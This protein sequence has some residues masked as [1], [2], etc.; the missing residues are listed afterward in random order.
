MI[1]ALL[2]AF[3]LLAAAGVP[4]AVG[5]GIAVILTMAFFTPLPTIGAMQR[6]ITGVDSFVLISIP[7]FML[8]G[9]L[10]NVGGITTRLFAFARSLVGPIRGGMAHANVLA[11]MILAGMSGSAVADAGGM[12]VVVIKAM[13]SQ[14]YR[15][16][17]AAAIT[18]AASTI[19]PII[20]PSIPMVI[21]GAMAEVS[22]GKLFLG[23]FVPGVL[24]GLSLMGLIAFWS[25]RERLPADQPYHLREI[26]KAFREAFLS[27]LTPIILIGGILSGIFTPTEA[28]AVAAVYAFVLSFFILRTVKVADIPGII[29]DTFVTTAVVTFI[30]STTSGF[31]YLL[32]I[33]KIGTLLV[34]S[35][36]ALTHNP[37]VV[38][39]IVNVA[40][41]ILG[42]LMEAGVLLIL[43]TP[44]LVP[45]MKSL[46]VDLV[47]FGLIM[48]LNL[49]IGVATPPVGMCLFVV[50]EAN[51]IKL[52]R[53]MREVIP[54][55]VPLILVLFLITYIPGL[56]MW[57]PNWLMAGK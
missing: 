39:L 14:G 33:G 10:M 19:G 8:T 26:W 41:L 35:T 37:Y 49:M 40:L 22:V 23:G 18:V 12:G 17:L 7:F 31:S 48:V 50:S 57:V 32:I 30:I 43:L 42:C 52:E 15:K 51:N 27:L 4:I 46:G 6:M 25:R 44:I 21:Y 5:M 11:N 1:T 28:S 56:V 34:E 20:P 47:H 29:V 2:I 54:W 24:M 38:L 55:C 36:L 45:L 3:V 13:Q 16:E 9:R 53:L